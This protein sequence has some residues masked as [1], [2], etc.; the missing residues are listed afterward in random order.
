MDDRSASSQ[1]RDGDVVRNTKDI[2]E[3]AAPCISTYSTDKSPEYRHREAVPE[4]RRLIEMSLERD[5]ARLYLL[6]KANHILHI[7]ESA[8]SR[9]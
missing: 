1:L 4:I 3:G 7:Y 6:A 9:S 5:N 8:G 2:V